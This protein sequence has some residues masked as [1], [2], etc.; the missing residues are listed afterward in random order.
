[1]TG[2]RR[3]L[4]LPSKKQKQSGRRRSTPPVVETS[5]AGG[6]DLLLPSKQEIRW[7]EEAKTTEELFLLPDR[8]HLLLVWNISR[9][10]EGNSLSSRR[11]LPINK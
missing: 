2:G 4:L 6:V 11:I 7:Q 9:R 10:R 5:N 8:E 3:H 1:M